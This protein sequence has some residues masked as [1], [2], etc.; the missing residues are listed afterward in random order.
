[1]SIGMN[2][3]FLVTE[4]Q[5]FSGKKAPEDDWEPQR[6]KRRFHRERYGF[7]ETNFFLA[8][9]STKCQTTKMR[10]TSLASKQCLL[11][12]RQQFTGGASRSWLFFDLK[13]IGTGTSSSSSR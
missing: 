12:G 7:T 6:L 13:R 4:Y 8:Q 10:W 2:L 3:T 5:T 9:N 11:E 1:M